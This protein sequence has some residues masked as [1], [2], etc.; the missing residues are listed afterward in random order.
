M[1]QDD[2]KLMRAKSASKKASH[3][4]RVLNEHPWYNEF[5]NRVVSLSGAKADLAAFEQQLIDQIRGWVY[6]SASYSRMV[7]PSKRCIEDQIPF[8]ERM[9]INIMKTIPKHVFGTD[10][11]QRI[12]RFLKSKENVPEREFVDAIERSGQVYS[13]VAFSP[14]SA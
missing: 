2:L 1:A 13:A 11:I 3:N 7:S 4:S 12:L 14:Q 5:V 9:L 10:E 8:K 6:N